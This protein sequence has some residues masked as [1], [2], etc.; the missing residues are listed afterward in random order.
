MLPCYL[1]WRVYYTHVCVC[2]CVC[3]VCVCCACVC[4][5][6]VCVVCVCVVCVWNASGMCREV[7]V[8]VLH[9]GSFSVLLFY[10]TMYRVP[11]AVFLNTICWFL[12]PQMHTKQNTCAC[13]Y[14]YMYRIHV[15][16][17]VHVCTCIGYLIP[18]ANMSYASSHA[19]L[20]SLMLSHT[21]TFF[22]VAF[23]MWVEQRGKGEEREWRGEQKEESTREQEKMK[24]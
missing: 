2:V 13:V 20:L 21:V 10:L 15:H 3:C 6:C 7:I 1:F 24:M 8:T 23:F 5:L 14:M 12:S 11:E 19:L 18:V 9:S 16:V 4:V 17:C 22:G